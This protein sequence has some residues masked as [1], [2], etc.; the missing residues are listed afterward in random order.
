M[1]YASTE[2]EEWSKSTSGQ[3]KDSIRRRRQL[4]F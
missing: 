1:R 4:E 3:I 2:A